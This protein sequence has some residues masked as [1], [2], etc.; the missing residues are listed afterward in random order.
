MV[1][2]YPSTS[3]ITSPQSIIKLMAMRPGSADGDGTGSPES[4]YHAVIKGEVFPELIICQDKINLFYQN[5]T[6][7]QTRPSEISFRQPQVANLIRLEIPILTDKL[8]NIL[9]KTTVEVQ[10]DFTKLN[11][12][13][14]YLNHRQFACH[15]EYGIIT[16]PLH[17]NRI[18]KNFANPEVIEGLEHNGQGIL[19][20]VPHRFSSADLKCNSAHIEVYAGEGETVCLCNDGYNAVGAGADV[21]CEKDEL[22]FTGLQNH[23]LPTKFQ[24]NND[25]CIQSSYHCDKEDDCMDN[26]D[27]TSCSNTT[28][29]SNEY[30]CK[31]GK[32]IEN[33]SSNPVVA[34]HTYPRSGV[35]CDGVHDCPDGD[36]EDE[37]ICLK[38]KQPV[39]CTNENFYRTW[40]C[41]DGKQCILSSS[42]CNGINDC[43][44]KT[45]EAH[46]A[47]DHCIDG[48]RQCAVGGTRS[49]CIKEEAYSEKEK[50]CKHEHPEKD[51][52][53]LLIVFPTRLFPFFH[54]NT[55]GIDEKVELIETVPMNADHMIYAG[56]SKIGH[57][58]AFLVLE[59]EIYHSRSQLIDIGSVLHASWNIPTFSPHIALNTTVLKKFRYSQTFMHNYYLTQ[60]PDAVWNEAQLEVSPNPSLLYLATA[61]QMIIDMDILDCYDAI[62]ILI[63]ET[64]SETGSKSQI[65]DR[66]FIAKLPGFHFTTQMGYK[67]DIETGIPTQLKTVNDFV[68]IVVSHNAT[69]TVKCKIHKMDEEWISIYS[70]SS[71]YLKIG[72]KMMPSSTNYIL[73][74][75][76]SSE[77]SADKYYEVVIKS[78]LLDGDQL[79][80]NNY[81]VTDLERVQMIGDM[82]SV[83]IIVEQDKCRM[84]LCSVAA[85]GEVDETHLVTLDNGGCEQKC[86]FDSKSEYGV[87][88]QCAC[89]PLYKLRADKKTC[90]KDYDN[91]ALTMTNIEADSNLTCSKDKIHAR[92]QYNITLVDDES[93]FWRCSSEPTCLLLPQVCDGVNDCGGGEDELFCTG[94]H[95]KSNYKPFDGDRLKKINQGAGWHRNSHVHCPSDYYRCHNGQCINESYVFWVEGDKHDGKEPEGDY[96]KS[97]IFGCYDRSNLFESKRYPRSLFCGHMPN[98]TMCNLPPA[99]PTV[100]ATSQMMSNDDPDADEPKTDDP[101]ICPGDQ[102]SCKQADSEQYICATVCNGIFECADHTDE[103]YCDACPDESQFRCT[104]GQCIDGGRQCD[105]LVDCDDLSDEVNCDFCNNNAFSCMVDIHAPDRSCI[106]PNQVCNRAYDC[107]S[108]LDEAD[109]EY[110]QSAIEPCPKGKY[111]NNA[112]DDCKPIEPN[113]CTVNSFPCSQI[114]IEGKPDTTPTCGCMDGYT[115]DAENKQACHHDP[116][117][118]SDMNYYP[119]LIF[120]NQ[121]S[122]RKANLITKQST[123]LSVGHKNIVAF[124][125]NWKLNRF[126]WTMVVKGTGSDSILKSTTVKDIGNFSTYPEDMLRENVT[127]FL[128]HEVDQVDAIAVDWITNNIYFGDKIGGRIKVMNQDAKFVRTLAEKNRDNTDHSQQIE[129]PRAIALYQPHGIFYFTDWGRQPHIGRMGMDGSNPEILHS[130]INYKSQKLSGKFRKAPLLGWP[131]D[132]IIDRTANKGSFNGSWSPSPMI[133]FCDAKFD[134]IV[135]TNLDFT[136]FHTIYTHGK[137]EAHVFSMTLFEEYI[138]FSDWK[139]NRKIFRIH[140]YCDDGNAGVQCTAEAITESTMDKPM[141]VVVVNPL[142]QPPIPHNPCE[143]LC[144]VG[145]D[146]NELCLLTPK[147]SATGGKDVDGVC[148][149]ADNWNRD[150]DSLVCKS[151]CGS[152]QFTCSDGRCIPLWK[153]NDGKQDCSNDES[154]VAKNDNLCALGFLMCPDLTKD[155]KDEVRRNRHSEYC[156]SPHSICDGVQDCPN[157]TDEQNCIS[158]DCELI[159]RKR[160]FK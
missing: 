40:K 75:F 88:V 57:Q 122:V 114:C 111:Y 1:I 49:L 100:P 44:D 67:Y 47:S 159:S 43:F 150:P 147:K 145:A 160:H 66:Y 21:T 58:D 30:K 71:L 42:K 65:A 25:L 14:G 50:H 110:S 61:N 116:P 7:R 95:A 142:L 87:S 115:I 15:P 152:F 80:Q 131:N 92:S 77:T 97:L 56:K 93:T 113:H 151:A 136:E 31:S 149:C 38:E 117:A 156:I 17:S 105:A 139:N 3:H 158:F 148:T 144:N 70:T 39:E 72:L 10:F 27:E 55:D 123:P 35:L 96:A 134:Y 62:F 18:Y 82:N 89:Q 155:H 69:N 124:D 74:I 102:K 133:Y 81:A 26:S 125:F 121:K 28:C 90:I 23:C 19:L 129:Y 141:A 130:N 11:E 99:V 64:G 52:Y 12:T 60:N 78:V 4:I 101:K 22:V 8:E 120:A 59:S 132:I 73:Y 45:D 83:D 54:I 41:L 98:S 5:Q 108:K 63:K 29:K 112:T 51:N 127:H 86:I 16:A 32:C 154:E 157:A 91:L 118:G 76:E 85:E 153:V 109:C 20:R 36:D 106:L 24:C 143:G 146:G 140:K 2:P 107:D 68:C 128:L 34:S 48:F 53:D 138:Y 103:M 9:A 104:N 79:D 33:H 6:L 135:R 126:Y 84:E 46:C 94:W 119:K 37:A 137:A 13:F